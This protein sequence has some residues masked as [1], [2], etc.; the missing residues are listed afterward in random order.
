MAS[1]LLA[2]IAL[3]SSAVSSQARCDVCYVRNEHSI[4][5]SVPF[6]ALCPSILLASNTEMLPAAAKQWCNRAL[7]PALLHLILWLLCNPI[8]NC[9]KCLSP[10]CAGAEPHRKMGHELESCPCQAHKCCESDLKWS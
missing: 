5:Y 6:S 3:C 4:D 9:Y 1:A 2:A 7:P 10:K 8:A